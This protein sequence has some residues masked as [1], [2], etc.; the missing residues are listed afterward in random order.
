MIKEISDRIAL[1]LIPDDEKNENNIELVSYGIEAVILN[2]ITFFSATLISL[3]IN[4]F[5]NFYLICLT[6]F[7][8]RAMHK[9]YHCKTYS[10]CLLISNIIILFMIYVSNILDSINV[11][12]FIPFLMILEY[13]VSYEKKIKILIFEI[14]YFIILTF[15]NVIY[16][17]FFF[18]AYILNIILIILGGDKNGFY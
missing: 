1:N 17:K 12:I 15:F 11:I 6:F 18:M 10:S 5:K 7:P 13:L 2:F 14:T 9:G 16:I 3:S 8:I 4:S